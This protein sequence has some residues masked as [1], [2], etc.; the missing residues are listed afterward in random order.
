VRD[1]LLQPGSDSRDETERF[2]GNETVDFVSQRTSM[3]PSQ[4]QL[5]ETLISL[6]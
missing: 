4:S 2:F 1:G 6:S 3:P 5:I